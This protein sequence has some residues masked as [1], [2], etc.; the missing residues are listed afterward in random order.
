MRRVLVFS[1]MFVLLA[2]RPAHAW[3]PLKS[4]TAAARK[5]GRTIGNV[6]GVGGF[7]ES[8]T[9]PTIRNA[10]ESGHRLIKDVDAALG[11]QLD[12]LKGVAGTVLVQTD[13]LVAESIV[14]VDRSLEGRIVQV[15]AIVDR[16]LDKTFDRVDLTIGRLD[17]VARKRIDQIAARANALID[18]A[19]KKARELLDQT[20]KRAAELLANT[21]AIIARRT[22]DLRQLVTVSI[23]QADDAAAARIDQL[24]EVAGRRIGSIDVIV[25]KQSMAIEVMLLR[26]GAL[27]A[28]VVFLGFVLWRLFRDAS[29]T[30]KDATQTTM[31]RKL[32]AVSAKGLLVFVGQATLGVAGVWLLYS[33]ST[34]LPHK[35]RV[36][37]EQ[38]L[39][40]HRSALRTAIAAY[41]FTSARY[42]STQLQILDTSSA[43]T[44]RALARKA[45]LLRMVL[46]RPALLQ[47]AAGVRRVAAELDDVEAELKSDPDILVLKALVLWRIGA[48]RRDEYD[49]AVLCREALTLGN[50]RREPFSLSVLARNYLRAFMHDPYLS[51]DVSAADL[52]RLATQGID[53]DVE[54]PHFQH[55]ITYNALVAELDHKSSS[56]YL[57]M[58]DAHVEFLI[59]RGDPKRPESASASA[60]RE[61]RSQAAG[62]VVAA[63]H[64]F[65]VELEASP[66]LVGDPT[67]LAAFTLDDAVLSH[68]LYYVYVPDATGL[69]P[70]FLTEKSTLT[71]QQRIQTAPLRVE[72]GRRYADLIGAHASDLLA[73]EETQRFAR[74]ERR[75]LD[76][77]RAYVS[78]AIAARATPGLDADGLAAAA[79]PAIV[80]AAEIGLFRDTSSGRRS[81]AA[82]LAET[83]HQVS[84]KPLSPEL[85]KTLQIAFQQRRLRFL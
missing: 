19:D 62:R 13:K 57:D 30:W 70:P 67:S 45:E 71:P 40:E 7:V 16:T 79:G 29:K 82:G 2:A 17:E 3:D 41:D 76:F 32:G 60:A 56:A 66:W 21:D 53:D 77:E 74:F 5:V 47:T 65:D 22:D 78:F 39:E 34:S 68:A 9:A 55:L 31:L 54:N 48:T 85:Q 72:W 26:V 15:G 42:H 27:I 1:T 59:A 36:R 20:S 58:L 4:V 38:H 83:L 12:N 51:D 49:A 61:R 81:V 24:D 35:T 8:A 10:E 80:A 50:D 44:Y 23:Q 64:A 52:Q 43:P 37:I 18:K 46:G 11:R 69:P 25:T 33:L 63:W 28:L 75:A 6:L 73:R 14:K 84:G